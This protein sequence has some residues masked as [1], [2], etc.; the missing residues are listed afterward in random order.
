MRHWPTVQRP[1]IAMPPAPPVFFFS[2]RSPYSWL[3][4]HDLKTLY[5]QLL[6]RL[7]LRPFWEPDLAYQAE[8]GAAG[9]AFLYTAMSKEKHLYILSD[10]KRLARRRGLE[11]R[12]PVDRAPSWEVPH[13]AYLH[14][15]QQGQGHQYIEAI[16]DM[17]WQ[18]GRD[19][20]DPA[21]VEAVGSALGMDAAA[22]R[23]AHRDPAIRTAGM[24]A[25]RTCIR[26][27]AFGVPFFTTGREK[28]W[29]IDRLSDFIGSLANA[30]TPETPVES[31]SESA[32]RAL[33]DHAGGCG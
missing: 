23:D 30:M 33:L 7:E 12:W 26:E 18:Q 5:P 1:S 27:G 11:V 21:T 31:T 3:A 32:N 17:R 24:K 16:T 8:L 28:F 25:L 4:L 9:E 15:E 2:L 29:G 10:I 19:I 20:C 13:L 6:A 14:A 22:L